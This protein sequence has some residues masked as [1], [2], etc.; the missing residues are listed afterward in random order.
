MEGREGGGGRHGGRRDR[1]ARG[2]GGREMWRCMGNIEEEETERG[3]EGRKGRGGR[4]RWR[5]ERKGGRGGEGEVEGR[6][7]EVKW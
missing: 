4:E 6:E 1:E 3:K 7:G 2:R 5:G